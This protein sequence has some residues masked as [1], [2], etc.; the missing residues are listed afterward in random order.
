MWPVLVTPTSA[1][2]NVICQTI[3]LHLVVLLNGL[4]AMERSNITRASQKFPWASAIIHFRFW[5]KGA[6]MCFTGCDFNA[7]HKQKVDLYTKETEGVYTWLSANSLCH[8][9]EETMCALGG[10]SNLS[11][12]L[13]CIWH[14]NREC[15]HSYVFPVWLGVW[16]QNPCTDSALPSRSCHSS[17]HQTW[18]HLTRLQVISVTALQWMQT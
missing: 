17:W 8:L 13:V 4:T 16:H 9:K 7:D 5:G 2:I 15:Q 14:A 1:G 18:A 12:N 6:M 11:Q 10:I 3:P